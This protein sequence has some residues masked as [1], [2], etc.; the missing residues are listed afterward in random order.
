LELPSVE[1]GGKRL[2]HVVEDP[3]AL[4]LVRLDPLPVLTNPAGCLRLDV[5]ED[6]RVTANELL[7]DAPRDGLE[8]SGSTFLQQ[9]REEV[10]LEQQVAE[11]VLELRVV[12]GKGGVGDLVGLLDRVRN[13]RLRRLL[14]IPGAVAAQA[15][16]QA[17]E[18]EECV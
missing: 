5:A 2:G 10:R 14:A 6:V 3:L 16:G 13:D 18:I 17:L 7:V 4:L 11:L 8:R 12:G 15:L 9:E 1:E